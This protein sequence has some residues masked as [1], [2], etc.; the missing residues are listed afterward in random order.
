MW[1]GQILV[2]SVEAMLK[3][4]F[5]NLVKKLQ[6]MRFSDTLLNPLYSREDACDSPCGAEICQCKTTE[7]PICG[8]K[9]TFPSILGYVSANE[10]NII[11]I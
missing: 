4:G 1:S 5:K 3:F 9:R 7:L 10:V 6:L 11:Y 8:G 2:R